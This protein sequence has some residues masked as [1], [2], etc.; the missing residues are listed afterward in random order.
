[1]CTIPILYVCENRG[2]RAFRQRRE[3]MVRTALA[4]LVLLALPAFSAEPEAKGERHKT[5]EGQRP[6]RPEP[7]VVAKF[8]LSH[9]Q[10]L[11]LTNEQKVKIE[12][13]VKEHQEKP[14]GVKPEGKKTEVDGKHGELPLPLKGRGFLVHR[15]KLA[16]T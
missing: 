16:R 10:E 1:L 6:P 3:S 5:G 12:A 4:I 9:A 11:S 13:F 15:T 7:G 14:E 8:I 2:T